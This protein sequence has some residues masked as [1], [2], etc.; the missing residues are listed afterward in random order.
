MERGR[1]VGGSGEKERE[2]ESERRRQMGK[3]VGGSSRQ[4]MKV[5]DL[6]VR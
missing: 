2:N 5:R 1:R 6:H 4:K 3:W